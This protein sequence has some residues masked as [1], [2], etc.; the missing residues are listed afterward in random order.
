[1]RPRKRRRENFDFLNI[2]PERTNLINKFLIKQNIKFVNFLSCT[3]LLIYSTYEI[4][5]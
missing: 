4:L 3:F 1:M 2:A 5:Y